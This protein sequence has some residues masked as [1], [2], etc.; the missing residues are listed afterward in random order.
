M[1]FS[2]FFPL[3]V[4]TS[5]HSHQPVVDAVTASSD[6]AS[7]GGV[8][9]ARRVRS[10]STLRDGMVGGANFSNGP[11]PINAEYENTDD[12]E[13]IQLIIM[14]ERESRKQQKRAKEQQELQFLRQQQQQQQR[15]ALSKSP[16]A[17]SSNTQTSS[18]RYVTR[19]LFI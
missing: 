2:F 6:Q 7:D 19:V 3:V 4:L 9:S 12:D 15:D 14:V 18:A 10:S 1:F 5:I 8:P 16:A 11:L 13:E 17:S